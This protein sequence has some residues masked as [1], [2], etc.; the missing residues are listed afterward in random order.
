MIQETEIEKYWIAAKKLVGKT[1][2]TQRAGVKF[3]IIKVEKGLKYKRKTGTYGAYSRKKIERY[4]SHRQNG[5]E[6]TIGSLYA[7]GIEK[8][9]K[10]GEYS[11]I[12]AIVDEILKI[13]NGK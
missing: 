11:Y 13:T 1:L 8:N 4:S 3:E 12:A 10:K 5:G 6:I 9:P 2:L 7:A